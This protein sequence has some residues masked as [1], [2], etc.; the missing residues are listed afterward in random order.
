MLVAVLT[1]RVGEHSFNY[2]YYCYYFDTVGCISET[3][4]N[5]Y[6]VLKGHLRDLAGPQVIKLGCVN[7]VFASLLPVSVLALPLLT[8]LSAFLG[9]LLK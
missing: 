1:V 9:A 2:S 3:A 8:L 7:A 4:C 6:I 5:L